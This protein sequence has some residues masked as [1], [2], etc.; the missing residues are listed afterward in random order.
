MA[1]FDYEPPSG[2]LDTNRFPSQPSS[3]SS[4]RGQFMTLFYQVRDYINAFFFTKEEVNAEITKVKNTKVIDVATYK[5]IVKDLNTGVITQYG[6]HTYSSNSLQIVNFHEPFPN[7]CLNVS[8][9]PTLDDYELS[10]YSKYPCVRR[11]GGINT[12]VTK[13]LFKVHMAQPNAI[14]GGFYWVATGI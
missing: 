9:T 6:Y 4:A 8:L 3:E 2:L 1:N 13:T 7:S 10:T 11:E 12:N 5:L 14:G